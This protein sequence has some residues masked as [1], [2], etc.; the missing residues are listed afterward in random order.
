MGHAIEDLEHWT[1][2]GAVYRVLELR[3]GHASVQLCSCTGEPVDRLESDDPL[4]I[5]YLMEKQRVKDP[6]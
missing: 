3:D 1:E 4:L 5:A 2:H 6:S